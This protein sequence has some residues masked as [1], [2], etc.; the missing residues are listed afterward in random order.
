MRKTTI[1]LA[2]ALAAT[3]T[4]AALL[5]QAGFRDREPGSGPG[6]GPGPDLDRLEMMLDQRADRV[7][8]AL[9]LTRDQRAAFDELRRTRLDAAKP[10]LEALREGAE[11]LR[12]LLDGGSADATEVG[13]RVI[14]LRELRQRLR[15]EREGFERDFSNLLTEKQ[16]FA[17][18][19]LLRARPGPDGDRSRGPRSGRGG[20][21]G[22]GARDRNR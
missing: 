2:G 12:A 20:P 15:A 19:A 3:L 6:F 21:H 17:W 18:E 14:A 7:A 11:E 9:E 16:R 1:L 10:D 4:S 5:A 8:D 13:E 22:F